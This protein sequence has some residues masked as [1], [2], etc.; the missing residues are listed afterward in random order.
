MKNFYKYALIIALISATYIYWKKVFNFDLNRAILGE[1][2]YLTCPHDVKIERNIDIVMSSDNNYAGQCAATMASILLNCDATSYLRFHISDGGISEENKSKIKE[3]TKIRPFDINFY[4]MN[5]YDWSIFPLNREWISVATYYRLKIPEILPQ[6]IEK[7]LYLDCDIIV[8]QD[9]KEL[10]ET[11]IS[12][13]ILGAVEDCQSIENSQRLNLPGNYF[14]AGVLLINLKE[15][16]KIDL[17]KLSREYLI[18]N[19]SVIIYQDQDILNGLFCKNCKF[20]PLKWNVNSLLLLKC[21]VSNFLLLKWKLNGFLLKK[22]NV[23]CK[24]SFSNPINASYTEEKSV[25]AARHPAIIHYTGCF[26]PWQ[27]DCIHPLKKEYFEYLK[28]TSFKNLSSEH[29][30]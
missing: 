8:E 17:M 5:K 25:E 4:D 14:N 21:N 24:I 28:Y 9:L 18:K 11:D 1:K 27:T 20:L 12:N 16:R 19:Q 3:L 13:V 7:V 29:K 30:N 26:K 10:W 23:N 15:L 6:H 22:C 2:I